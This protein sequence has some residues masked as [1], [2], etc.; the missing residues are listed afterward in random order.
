MKCLYKCLIFFRFNLFFMLNAHRCSTKI[1]RRCLL[2]DNTFILQERKKNCNFKSIYFLLF[3][4]WREKKYNH[5]FRKSLIYW[6]LYFLTYFFFVVPREVKHLRGKLLSVPLYK[7]LNC[8]WS[9]VD[10]EIF[11]DGG[12]GHVYVYNKMCKSV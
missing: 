5:R 4:P 10:K 1:C 8:S 9:Y 6:L 2:I 7:H 12:Q 3:I 11:S